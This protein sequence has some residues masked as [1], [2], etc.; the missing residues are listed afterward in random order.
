[1]IRNHLLSV[2]A[3]AASFSLISC[4]G[5]DDSALR[6][7]WLNPP[8]E[9]RMN[10]NI[11]NFPMDQAGQDS[12]IRVTLENGWGGFTLNV[13][14]NLYLTDE[15]MKG[16]KRFCEAAKA[17]GMDLWLYDE[18]GYPSGNAGDLVIREDP[19]WEAMGIYFKDTI[20]TKGKSRFLMPPGDL[21]MIVAFPSE[22]GKA[23]FTSPLDLTTYLD[24]S[25][26]EWTAPEGQ[27]N[28]FASSKYRLYEGFQAEVK[29]GGKVGAHYPSLMMREVTNAF[30][31]ITHEKYASYMGNDLGKY[32]TSTFTDEPSLMAVQFH[33]NKLNF[34]VIPWKEVLSD[35]MEKRYGY[36]P[37][38]K[39]VEFYFDQGPEGQKLRY[40]YFQ[41]AG[42]LMTANY[43]EPIKA[44]CE[45]HNFLSGGHLLLEETMIAH[46]PLYGNIMEC[47]RAMDAPGIDIL[48]CFPEQMPVHSPKLASS[49]A[50]LAGYTHVMSEPCPVADRAV[51]DGKETPAESVRG[52]LNMLMQG[53]ITDFNCYLQLSNSDQ[54]EKNE[55]NTYVGRISM[56]L[57]GGHAASEIGV[58]Y[59]IESLWTR[60]TPRYHKVIEWTKV[61]GATEAANKINESFLNVSRFM[62]DHRWEYTHL[63]A[64][65]LM[66]GEIDKGCL[67]IDPFRFKVI[68][69]PSVTTLPADAWTRLLEF[70]DN[71]GKILALEERP[72]NSDV[73]FPDAAI[74]DAFARLFDTGNKVVFMKY[75]TPEGVENLL[76]SWLE[77]EIVL[78][79]ET[80]PLALAHKQIEGRDLFFIINDSKEEVHTK[81]SFRTKGKLEEWD[82]DS[83]FIKAVSSNAEIVLKPYHGKVYR[84]M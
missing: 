54:A 62:Y 12:L 78:S 56:L 72:L 37:E 29:G 81:V 32:F 82:P 76:N 18:N 70:A 58:V 55:F 5:P 2:F 22:D 24:G 9:Y 66:E 65:A 51:L 8:L 13:P 67:D 74:R 61:G 75:W 38:E 10:R 79:D 20:V 50:E 73:D 68:V 41:T 53:G 14:F 30:I 43:F 1:M 44:W 40:Q 35:E 69:L 26:L 15:G 17:K 23:N 52:H 16:T 49:S 45:K 27:W 42:D 4:A 7:S 47:F 34:A 39:L 3:V 80:L 28:L 46:V 19:S 71:G 59:P 77:K 25:W 36:R 64:R 83:G 11:H 21:Q 33:Q 6:E 84:T 48:S 63:D 31:R 57:Q 60:F